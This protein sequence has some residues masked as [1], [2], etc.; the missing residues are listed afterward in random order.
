MRPHCT[1]VCFCACTRMRHTASPHRH[2]GRVRAIQGQSVL[3]GCGPHVDEEDD[4]VGAT[5]R[6]KGSGALFHASAVLFMYR[7]HRITG[8]LPPSV[9]GSL[10]GVL[11]RAHVFRWRQ[12]HQGPEPG[13][14]DPSG[15]DAGLP[16]P[17]PLPYS[18]PGAG[19]CMRVQMG[20]G[21][22]GGSV[23]VSPANAARAATWHGW[24]YCCC[25]RDLW[26]VRYV[27]ITP[28]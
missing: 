27:S 9:P 13:G 7:G 2:P 6:G 25:C 1:C 8:A 10:A 17:P 16:Q 12:L 19:V 20:K 11:L 28:L 21:G 23:S 14:R 15:G 24:L 18:G 4:K 3:R 26:P 5:S 22:A